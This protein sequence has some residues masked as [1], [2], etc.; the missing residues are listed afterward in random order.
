MA[1]IMAQKSRDIE[2]EGQP[3]M[4]DETKR[5]AEHK[6]FTFDVIDIPTDPLR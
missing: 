4:D 5:L 6:R 3:E 2:R 1:D